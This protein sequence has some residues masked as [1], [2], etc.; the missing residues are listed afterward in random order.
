MKGQVVEHMNIG[1]RDTLCDADDEDIL[2]F[3]SRELAFSELWCGVHSLL[4]YLFSEHLFCLSHCFRC[5][6]KHK[7]YHG[8][9][10]HM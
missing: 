8:S 2:K 10:I 1:L 5:W 6:R 9:E 7:H 3:L 4:Q